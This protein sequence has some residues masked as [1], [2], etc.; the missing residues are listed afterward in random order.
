MEL[1]HFFVPRGFEPDHDLLY[2]SVWILFYS[3]GTIDSLLTV[4]IIA[5]LTRACRLL[6]GNQWIHHQLVEHPLAF[7]GVSVR[8]G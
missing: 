8:P 7:R 2:P 3:S 5:L 6:C 1:K 4:S